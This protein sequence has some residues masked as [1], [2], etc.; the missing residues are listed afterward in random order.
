M[1]AEREFDRFARRSGW[2]N[3]DDTAGWQIIL[4]ERFMVGQ[5][6]ILN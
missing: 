2:R 6:P 3:D 1:Q 5:V 4:Y